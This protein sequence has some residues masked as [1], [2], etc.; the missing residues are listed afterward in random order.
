MKSRLKGKHILIAMVVGAAAFAV[1]GVAYATIPSS[2]GVY[3]G[4]VLKGVGSLR[5]IDPSA[6][7]N[8]LQNRCLAPF[9]QQI[10]WN[11]TGPQGPP[12]PQGQQGATGPAGA[13]GAAGTNGAAGATGPT[14]AT[15]PKGPQGPNATGVFLD[16]N[17]FAG[18]PVSQTATV[19][20]YTL[21]DEC[22]LTGSTASINLSLSYGAAFNFAGGGVKDSTPFSFEDDAYDSGP[23]S[24]YTI[25][26]DSTTTDG[27]GQVEFEAGHYA[28]A[29]N[30]IAQL[31]YGVHSVPAGG[32]SPFSLCVVFGSIEP[33][34]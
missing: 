7:G 24:S 28:D 5:L 21:T 1:A 26:S 12:G 11:Q 32:G 31:G 4:C 22:T 13:A 10:T 30:I 2:S 6:G 25:L 33:T 15:G 23:D 27:S 3:T 20:G 18:E 17:G 29:A 16:P 14:G 19:D 8:S 34:Q 9:E